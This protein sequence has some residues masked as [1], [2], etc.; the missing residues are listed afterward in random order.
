M[1][2]KSR[3]AINFNQ[4]RFKQISE[5]HCGP[6][7][8]QMLLSNLGIEVSQEQVAEAGGATSL[9][10]M[11]GMRV[12]QLALAVYHL[13]PQVVFYVKDHAT[14]DELV[15]IV[16]DYRH[17]VGVEWQGVFEDEDAARLDRAN[18]NWKPRAKGSQA[19]KS[20]IISPEKASMPADSES[21]DTDYGHYSLVTYAKRRRKELIIAD[22]YKDFFSQARIFGFKEFEE[23]WYDFNEVPDPF[24]GQPQVVEDYHLMF[25][26]VRR[27]VVFPLRM[28]MHRILPA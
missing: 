20:G 2:R 10:A 3:P 8:I 11:N 22:P 14:L 18:Q 4:E 25:V 23:R 24:G 27:N 13:A 16:K 5:S 19:R 17:P 12:D 26:V 6:A 28:G 9:I 7:A 15:R 21:R 1:P